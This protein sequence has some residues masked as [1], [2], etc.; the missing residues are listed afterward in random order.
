MLAIEIECSE[1]QMLLADVAGLD[2][3]YWQMLAMMLAWK[4]V[5]LLTS[6]MFRAPDDAN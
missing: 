1:Q 4:L 5:W 3:C 2:R 6:P